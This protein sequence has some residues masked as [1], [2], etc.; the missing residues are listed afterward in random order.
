[1]KHPLTC[2]EITRR[3]L[4][5]RYVAGRLSETD[6]EALESHYL[7]CDRCYDELRLAAAI[8]TTLPEVRKDAA[9]EP[10]PALSVRGRRYGHRWKIGV[11]GLAAAAVLAGVLLLRPSDLDVDRD[12]PLHRENV[13]DVEAAPT[14]EV[15]IGEIV[16]LEEFRWAPVTSADLYRVTVY[17]TKGAVIWEVET[18]ETHAA[19]PDATELEPG[20]PYLWEVE[21]RVGWDQWVSSELVR[22]RISE[23]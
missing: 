23:P 4:I 6:A 16:A 8:W 1:M 13:P 9:A 14:A 11:A 10:Q 21:A 22:F 3:A 19:P 17:D 2:E 20:I 7:T 5:E 12:A 15:P 18:R